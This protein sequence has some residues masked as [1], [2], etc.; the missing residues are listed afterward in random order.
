MTNAGIRK[1]Q[2][3]G[4][5]VHL[6]AVAPTPTLTRSKPSSLTVDEAITGGNGK[7]S[8]FLDRARRSPRLDYRQLPLATTSDEKPKQSQ[9][10]VSVP[11]LSSSFPSTIGMPGRVTKNRKFSAPNVL[12]TSSPF[13]THVEE[14]EG[15]YLAPTQMLTPTI[16]VAHHE[17]DIGLEPRISAGSAPSIEETTPKPPPQDYPP[18][19]QPSQNIEDKGSA[20]QMAPTEVYVNMSADETGAQDGNNAGLISNAQSYDSDYYLTVLDVKESP[21]GSIAAEN[22]PARGTRE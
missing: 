9:R 17:S 12:A 16:N 18:S 4:H 5:S 20:R 2:H 1:S 21:V 19:T 6:D 10:K 7:N 3:K 15:N 22:L 11:L 13:H 14:T 8:P